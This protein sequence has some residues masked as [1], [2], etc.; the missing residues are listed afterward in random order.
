MSAFLGNRRKTPR[1]P[2]D[3]GVDI[4]RHGRWG[5]WRTLEQGARG[6]D[7]NRFGM[8]FVSRRRW[9]PG[10]S[11]RLTL[12]GPAMRLHN[13]E[14]WV[15]SIERTGQG[16]RLGVRFYESLNA[17]SRAPRAPFLRYLSG[18]EEQ[19]PPA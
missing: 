4:R 7:F 5:G 6:L 12:H 19:L 1:R 16:Y 3:I 15:V 9:R 10:Q 13:V 18:L 11:L 14:A 2:A 8:A 17:L